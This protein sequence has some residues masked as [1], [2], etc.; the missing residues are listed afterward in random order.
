MTVIDPEPPPDNC[1]KAVIQQGCK[2]DV[3]ESNVLEVL[4]AA[5]FRTLV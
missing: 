5:T 4:P 3:K 2:F 1:Y